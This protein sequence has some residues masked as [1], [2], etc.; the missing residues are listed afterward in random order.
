MCSRAVP[1]VADLNGSPAPDFLRLR[2]DLG[3]PKPVNAH[4]NCKRFESPCQYRKDSKPTCLRG[5]KNSQGDGYG[6]FTGVPGGIICKIDRKFTRQA[7]S[8][9]A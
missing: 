2:E 5:N 4:V 1:A 6:A 7:L 3:F 9:F 8:L